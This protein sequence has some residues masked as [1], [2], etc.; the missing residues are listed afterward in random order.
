MFTSRILVYSKFTT[1]AFDEA[2]P[3]LRF[4]KK[5][6]KFLY[7][8]VDKEKSADLNQLKERRTC[9]HPVLPIFEPISTN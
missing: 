2:Y 8:A 6:A 4:F 3:I 7:P 1:N 5:E 9:K